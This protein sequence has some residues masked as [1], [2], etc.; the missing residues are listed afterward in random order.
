MT[1]VIRKGSL[2]GEEGHAVKARL[3]LAFADPGLWR[4]TAEWRDMGESNRTRLSA[5]REE[6]PARA[7]GRLAAELRERR[8]LDDG[9]TF[10]RAMDLLRR[11]APLMDREVA[12]VH[13]DARLRRMTRREKDKDTR[14][15]MKEGA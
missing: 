12:A 2:G 1:Q 11:A 9:G 8:F 10:T 13:A 5:G 14:W 15:R 3:G 4:A 6:D 7:L